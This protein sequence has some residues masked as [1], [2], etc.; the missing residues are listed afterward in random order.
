MWSEVQL[1]YCILS[2]IH[3]VSNLKVI[4]VNLWGQ[5]ARQQGQRLLD[6]INQAN[7]PALSKL[8]ARTFHGILLTYEDFPLK[9][10]HLNV[11]LFSK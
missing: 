5:F 2:C 11:Q 1:I 3:F 10:V 9:Y 4:R 7:V 6:T 8:V